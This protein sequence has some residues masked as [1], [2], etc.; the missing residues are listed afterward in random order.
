MFYI[1]YFCFIFIN[2]YN[3]NPWEL[4]LLIATGVQSVID[5]MKSQNYSYDDGVRYFV[6]NNKKFVCY[7]PEMKNNVL[8]FEIRPYN[9]L[10]DDVSM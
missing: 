6:K 1:L 4:N 3:K 9:S 7:Y 10:I 8:V 2:F 5:Y